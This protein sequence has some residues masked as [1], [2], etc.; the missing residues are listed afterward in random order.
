MLRISALGLAFYG[1][2]SI[3]VGLENFFTGTELD[4]WASLLVILA[5]TVVLLSAA[6]V[7][8]SIMPGGLALAVGGLL[9]LQSVS[10]HNDSHLYGQGPCC[11][12]SSSVWG[13][14]PSW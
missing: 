14:L 8:V 3:V 2:Y 10:L 5:G 12:P 6:C 11:F 1:F 9:G 13:S 7:R 4:W